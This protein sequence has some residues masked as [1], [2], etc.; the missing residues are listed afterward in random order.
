MSLENPFTPNPILPPE[1]TNPKATEFL[2]ASLLGA[3][4]AKKY[5]ETVSGET[6]KPPK[7]KPSFSLNSFDEAS[8]DIHEQENRLE[9]KKQY[10]TQKAAFEQIGLL[11]MREGIS[12]ITDIEGNWHVFPT[13]EEVK[14]RLEAK[15]EL[16]TTKERQGFKKLLIVP[17]GMPIKTFTETMKR[18]LLAHYENKALFSTNKDGTREALK[19]NTTQPLSVWDKYQDADTNNTIV[20]FPNTLTAE[21]HGGKTKQA[22]LTENHAFH[23]LLLEEDLVIPGQGEGTEQGGRQRIE[24]N[25]TPNAYLAL[26]KEEPYQHEHGLT[27]EAWMTLFLL[28]LE[29]TNEVIDDY[30]GQGKVSYNLGAY[31]PGSGG[32]SGGY[33][34]RDVAR[35]RVGGYD[36]EFRDANYGSRS[37]VMV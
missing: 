5:R 28:H 13:L 7:E 29:T 22:L 27:P 8:F 9:L 19:L 23:I 25:Q 10:T 16:I 33:W 32:V 2:I 36:P 21:N 31:F 24:A 11:E 4:A 34:D 6:Q 1:E 26:L 12:G 20:Y 35:A 18:T 30:Q 15:Q 3:T 14:Q 37:A 17:F